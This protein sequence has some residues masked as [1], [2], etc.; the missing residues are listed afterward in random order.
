M[1]LTRNSNAN[2]SGCGRH[3]GIVQLSPSW[4]PKEVVVSLCVPSSTTC[5]VA[6]AGPP[7]GSFRGATQQEAEGMIRKRAFARVEHAERVEV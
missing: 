1:V 3:Y 4:I 2:R 7:G 6:A 5:L